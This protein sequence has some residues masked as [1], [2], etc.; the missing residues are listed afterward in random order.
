M[1]VFIN[2]YKFTISKHPKTHT[3]NDITEFVLD[4][5]SNVLLLNKIKDNKYNRK[6]YETILQA[7]PINYNQ[8]NAKAHST[9]I[10]ELI[11]NN[12][13]YQS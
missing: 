5:G 11:T 1:L 3:S 2:V 10:Y 12:E 9:S 7:A 4:K 13:L 8:E 6:N